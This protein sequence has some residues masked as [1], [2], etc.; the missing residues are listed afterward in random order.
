MSLRSDQREDGESTS[1]S[2]EA[3]T[4]RYGFLLVNG[5]TNNDRSV[6]TN[7]LR[8]YSVTH[9]VF[10]KVCV[11]YSTFFSQ[12]SPTIIFSVALNILP[13]YHGDIGSVRVW[14]PV[15]CVCVGV[16]IMTVVLCTL[17]ILETY[18]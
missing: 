17:I 3:K 18:S 13:H 2:S 9:I 5:D 1:G 12:P 14:F 11:Q 8:T 15:V 10:I 6:L 4:D 7:P 16:Y